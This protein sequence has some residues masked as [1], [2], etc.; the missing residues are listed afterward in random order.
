MREPGSAFGVGLCVILFESPA[1][2]CEQPLSCACTRAHTHTH[3]YS[4]S[5]SPAAVLDTLI[6]SVFF[7]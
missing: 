2:I 4:L 5:L 6:V 3:I 7:C 1:V